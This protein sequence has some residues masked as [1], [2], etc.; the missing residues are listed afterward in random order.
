[1]L[2]RAPYGLSDR[3]TH[4]GSDGEAIT[5]GFRRLGLGKVIGMRTWG[6][7]VWLSFSNTEADNGIA[8]AAEL[9]VYGPDGKWLIEGHG[10]D[11]DV[12]VDNLPHATFLGEDEQLEAALKFLTEQIKTDPRPHNIHPIPT[13]PSDSLRPAID[14][15]SSKGA[16]K[17]AVALRGDATAHQ[18]LPT[19]LELSYSPFW[20]LWAGWRTR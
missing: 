4:S 12:A 3:R 2:F 10:V 9:G 19:T 13:N 7:E 18:I 6:G 5:E 11:P 1:M 16:E 8:S 14:P 20:L 17:G 15:W